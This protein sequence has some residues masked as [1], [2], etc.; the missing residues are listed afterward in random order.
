[1]RYLAGWMLVTV[2]M[3]FALGVAYIENGWRGVGALIV[4]ACVF[5]A[6]VGSVFAGAH[7][8]DGADERER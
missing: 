7:L 6:V 3:W 2:P 5:G 1:M 4:V 8:L